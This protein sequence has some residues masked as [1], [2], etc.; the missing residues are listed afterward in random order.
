MKSRNDIILEIVNGS[1]IRMRESFFKKNHKLLYN[2]IIN[3]IEKNISFRE[4]LWYWVNN[5]N[6]IQTCLC[7]KPTSF[8]KNWLNGYKK[9]CSVR[10]SHKDI[11]THE[12][13][14]K[15]CLES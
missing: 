12:K 10:C 5:I 4:K 15:T 3:H 9:F 1:S 7:G 14:K 6:I 13:Y 2:N 8:N 11:L